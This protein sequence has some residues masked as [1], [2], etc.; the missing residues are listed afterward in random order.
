M[1]ILHVLNH[2]FRLNGHVHAAVDL[3]CAQAD[4]GHE[5]AVA[6]EGGHF[7][8]LLQRRGVETIILDQRRRPQ[9]M[10][11]TS[12]AL[13]RLLGRFDVAHAHMI[14]SA[15]LCFLP[16]KLRK[17]PLITTV[18]NEFE[19][20]AAV[21]GVG[22]RVIGVSQ[23]VTAS[24]KRR[25]ISTTRLRTVLNGTV[26]SAR[27]AGPAPT[28]IDLGHPA[29]LFV[30]GLHPRK[31]LP[32]LLE[33]FDKI[34]EQVPGASLHIVGEGPC[35]SEYRSIAGKLRASLYV[36]FHGAHVDPRGFMRAADILVL[37]SLA[38]P[39]GLVLSEA[40]EAGCAIVGSQV[41]GIPEM[42]D[43]GR[44]GALVP[45]G[46]AA[47][48]AKV[49]SQLLRDPVALAAA[50]AAARDNV[51]R[52]GVARVADETLSIYSECLAHSFDDATP[53]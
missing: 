7:D 15:L 29:V 22:A 40:C 6:S 44:A 28:S 49:L 21:M 12:L 20:S 31:G 36:K 38:E 16:C 33:A 26:G 42:L 5:V 19:R 32:I 10:M 14:T 45:P 17:V 11:S 48:L 2:T 43:G 52:M 24:L 50:K 13:W 51:A 53:S 34:A 9:Q 37:P 30:G 35:E 47:L 1:R 25:G 41:G 46:D 27:F 18:H 3:A 4:L 23:A 8:E 39:A